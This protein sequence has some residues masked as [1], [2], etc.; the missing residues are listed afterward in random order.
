MR[1]M[2]KEEVEEIIKYLSESQKYMV[3]L[4]ASNNFEAIKNEL[5]LQKELFLVSNNIKSL[6]E[7]SNFQPHFEG[8]YSE[9]ARFELGSLK[10]DNIIRMEHGRIFLTPFGKQVAIELTKEFDEDILK[11]V[12]DFKVLLND[13]TERELLIFVY[14]TFG[15]TEES[16]VLKRLIPYRKEIATSL[17]KKRKIS[18]EKMAEIAG[19]S[20]DEAM[21]IKKKLMVKTNDTKDS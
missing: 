15:M 10:I 14:Y 18:L 12:E 9:T 13:L 17:Y 1:K 16:L 5:F 2:N 7:H 6:K 11:M 19:I 4:L 20:I 21:S 8:P 3:L